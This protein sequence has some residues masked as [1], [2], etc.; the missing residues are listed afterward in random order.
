MAAIEVRGLSRTYRQGQPGEVKALDDV[1]LG[2]QA[3]E[4]VSVVGRAGSGKTTLLHCLG[5]LVRPTAGQV[6]IDGVDT[7]A[8]SDDERAELRGR[9]IG[10]VLQDGNLLPA[11][12]V[13]ENVLLPL[14]YAWFRRG[15]RSRARELLDLVGMADQAD[16]R[17]DQL[18][19][20]QAQ[21]VA[22]A[23]SLIKAPVA[24]LADEPTGEVDDETSDELLYLMQQ[25]NRMNDVTFVVATHDP[26]V[27]SVMDRM[28]RVNGGKVVADQRLRGDSV[29]LS[30]IR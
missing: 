4:F 12:T 14:R 2:V 25:V 5:L 17:P 28:I 7:A 15:A 8:L 21:R 3:G 19:P 26:E 24:V 27:A 22:I 9:R 23:R 16:A 6:L 30:G 29:R 13:L 10:F 18:K 20:G 11:L 1:T